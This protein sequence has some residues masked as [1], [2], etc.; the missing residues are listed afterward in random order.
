[1]KQFHE[2]R[3][4]RGLFKSLNS[5]QPADEALVYI[6][7]STLRVTLRI[8]AKGYPYD[9]VAPEGCVLALKYSGFVLCNEAPMTRDRLSEDLDDACFN[10]LTNRLQL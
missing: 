6:K 8:I 7:P 1:M 4:E 10:Y 2:Y 3:F 5:I 9:L